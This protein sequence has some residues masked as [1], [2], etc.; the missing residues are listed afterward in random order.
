MNPANFTPSLVR[1]TVCGLLSVH[2]HALVH[3]PEATSD[4]HHSFRLKVRE[5]VM[6]T[7]KGG[8]EIDQCSPSPA[9]EHFGEGQ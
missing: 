6:Q 5:F 7:K 9:F 1:G 2:G 3:G 8:A 4:G